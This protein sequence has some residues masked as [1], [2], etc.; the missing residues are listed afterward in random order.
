VVLQART[1]LS[2][3]EDAIRHYWDGPRAYFHYQIKRLYPQRDAR[4]FESLVARAPVLQEQPPRQLVNRVAARAKAIWR[5]ADDTYGYALLAYRS[6]LS[7][8]ED[9]DLANV[10]ASIAVDTLTYGYAGPAEHVEKD[11]AGLGAGA[12][13]TLGWL[14]DSNRSKWKTYWA[15]RA[16]GPEPAPSR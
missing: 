10:W 7:L 1:R 11:F 5:G 13:G 9:P 16:R 14:S 15:R 4:Q 3:C 2:T 12:L 8:P 6:A